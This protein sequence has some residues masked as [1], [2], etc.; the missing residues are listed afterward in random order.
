MQ[1]DEKD[2][3]RVEQTLTRTE[4]CLVK[5]CVCVCAGC[6][7]KERE[8][9]NKEERERERTTGGRHDQNTSHVGK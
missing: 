9:E 2:M 4:L 1:Q 7:S 5:K 8:R 6:G 3:Q